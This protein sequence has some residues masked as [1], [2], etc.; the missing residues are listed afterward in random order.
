MSTTTEASTTIQ[1][2]TF[3]IENLLLGVNIDVV[4]EINRHLEVTEVPHSPPSV[5]GVVN[6]RGEVVTVVDLRTLLGLKKR[7]SE[8]NCKCVVIHSQEE[9]IGVLVDEIADTLSVPQSKIDPPPS[10]IDGVEGQYFRGV[11][12]LESGVVILLDVQ[13]LLEAN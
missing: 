8:T 4:Q 6:L 1:V 10:N 11:Y 2:A 13:Q 9:L 12:T 3:Y 5:R 7:D